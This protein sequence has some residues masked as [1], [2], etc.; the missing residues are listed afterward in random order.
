VFD[1]QPLIERFH[2]GEYAAVMTEIDA[3]WETAHGEASRQIEADE[4]PWALV[5]C[6]RI[7][8]LESGMRSWAATRTPSIVARAV[9]LGLWTPERALALTELIPA[10]SENEAVN[11]MSAV[12]GTGKLGLDAANAAIDRARALLERR[13]YASAFDLS[14]MKLAK[15]AGTYGREDL[16][17]AALNAALEAANG[18]YTL[19]TPALY[20]LIPVLPESLLDAARRGINEI[21]STE[22]KLW[23]FAALAE[24]LSGEAREQVLSLGLA[25][26]EAMLTEPGHALPGMPTEPRP[27][28]DIDIANGMLR[29]GPHLAGEQIERALAIG[30]QFE[31]RQWFPRVVQALAPDLTPEQW[32]RALDFA[33]TVDNEW[34]RGGALIQA[35]RYTRGETQRKAVLALLTIND[36]ETR[37]KIRDWY[38]REDAGSFI[39]DE[40][41]REQLILHI[42][43]MEARKPFEP[44]EWF[45]DLVQN[46][47]DEEER[48]SSLYYLAPQLP[49]DLLP[50]LADAVTHMVDRSWY[51]ESVLVAA[52]D[53]L[54][55]ALVERVL[56]TPYDHKGGRD[57]IGAL[58]RYSH[59]LR[60]HSIHD[61]VMTYALERVL[62]IP[63]VMLRE[64]QLEAVI[65]DF[66]GAYLHK[67]KQELYRLIMAREPQLRWISS[68][69]AVLPYLDDAER[70]I[71][72]PNFVDNILR[73]EPES[74]LP[75]RIEK[76]LPYQLEKVLPL[77]E[78]HDIEQ[79]YAVTQTYKY[80]ADKFRQ[81]VQPYLDGDKTAAQVKSK[82]VNTAEQDIQVRRDVLENLHDSRPAFRTSV[83]VDC[84]Y[85]SKPN[86]SRSFSPEIVAQ[87]A[88]E[89]I[90]A[91]QDGLG[92]WNENDE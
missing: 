12:I 3:A 20:E 23:A 57:F 10:G 4:E 16:G 18:R 2:R 31:E 36:S 48:A 79:I 61:E 55:A 53:R 46:E 63:N 11:L 34:W 39:E 32:E 45:Y 28:K 78:R 38:E 26:A 65:Q 83:L 90:A 67:V 6:V 25:A 62:A 81:L 15:A 33:F 56:L 52:A 84:S 29:L 86:I 43:D 59:W 17:G 13:E 82:P 22:S 35:A 40:A 42:G 58:C 47:K 66:T 44:V 71:L 54:G 8:L 77:L 70:K 30:L 91:D 75:F 41:L 21:K 74:N 85:F 7:A 51:R 87:F 5:E 37:S 72:L 27:R 89:V 68:M 64:S 49:E 73:E 80:Y 69:A 9:E 60:E 1:S 24:R 76:V 88:R 92:S 50:E 19:Y 14:Y